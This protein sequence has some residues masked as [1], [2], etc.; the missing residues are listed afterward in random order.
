ML[1]DGICPRLLCNSWRAYFAPKRE[2]QGGLVLKTFKI[3]GQQLYLPISRR[4]FPLTFLK[5]F[6]FFFFNFR[7]LI[8]A[9]RAFGL[10]RDSLSSYPD[11][12]SQSLGWGLETTHHLNQFSDQ[13]GV[14]KPKKK[15]HTQSRNQCIFLQFRQISVNGG[16]MRLELVA[17]AVGQQKD[18]YF[19]FMSW[20]ATRHSETYLFTIG[21]VLGLQTQP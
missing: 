6:Y 1:I 16:P 13:L 5:F 2:S 7:L 11:G 20:S 19:S 21:I 10:H 8:S 14:V 17:I 18:F 15:V 3:L 9:E 12:L 4:L